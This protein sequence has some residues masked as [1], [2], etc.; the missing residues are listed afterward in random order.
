MMTFSSVR[1]GS[2][3]V[4]MSFLSNSDRLG[5]PD[6]LTTGAIVQTLVDVNVALEAKMLFAFRAG[7][8]RP[9]H[10]SCIF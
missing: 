7:N 3:L 6:A 4:E 5:L 10:V 2:G 9:R 8:T 1:I